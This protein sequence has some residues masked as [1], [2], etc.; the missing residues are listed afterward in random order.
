VSYDYTVNFKNVDT[1]QRPG[2]LSTKKG[3]LTLLGD[4]LDIEPRDDLYGMTVVPIRAFGFP[5]DRYPS[6][7]VECRYVDAANGI[8]LQPSAVLNSQNQEV[9]WSLFMCDL[10]DRSFDYRLTYSLA[11]GGTIVS[12][13]TTTN[14][15]KID[16][17]DPFPTKITLTILAALD[18]M[19]FAEALVFVAYPSKTAP[20]VQQSFT[21]NQ[22]NATAP[23][24]EVDRQNPTQNL[25]YYE[26]RLIRRDGGVW[27]VPGSVTSAQYLILQDGM[28]GHQIISIVPEQVDF[29][30]A[31]ISSISVQ[32]RY[33][34]PANSLNIQETVT[35]GGAG[36]ARSFS[37]DYLNDQIV[38]QYRADIALNNGQTKSIDWTQID[39]NLVTI[40]LSQ[41]N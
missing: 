30:A 35:L 13:W 25:I 24:F 29:S 15:A 16:I 37:Y 33:V 8:D 2:R 20:V 1:T 41:L 5:W 6:V 27:T 39:G 10:S 12:P 11:A 9:D 14:G 34:D 4:V 19:K 38:P 23:P 31:Q 17:V 28:K 22:S 18:W 7:E 21:L 3:G 40:P 32:L 26:A 36:D